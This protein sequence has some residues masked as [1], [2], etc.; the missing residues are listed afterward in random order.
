MQPIR[1]RSKPDRLVAGGSK[2]RKNDSSRG[3]LPQKNSKALEN[4]IT[5]D[6]WEYLESGDANPTLGLEFL[7]PVGWWNYVP[8]YHNE[9]DKV[10]TDNIDF[11]PRNS[12]DYDFQWTLPKDARPARIIDGNVDFRK[13]DIPFLPIDSYITGR[14]PVDMLYEFTKMNAFVAENW[15]R[16]KF[17]GIGGFDD[18]SRNYAKYHIFGENGETKWMDEEPFDVDFG[19]KIKDLIA[20]CNVAINDLIGIRP[21]WNHQVGVLLTIKARQQCAHLDYKNLDKVTDES[22][23]PW[24]VVLPLTEEGA[25]INVWPGPSAYVEEG[26]TFKN[27]MKEIP[28]HH[29]RLVIPFGCMLMLRSDIVHG[30]SF[31]SRGNTRMHLALNMRTTIEA[32]QNLDC[33]F[34]PTGA[35]LHYFR[36]YM[37]CYETYRIP[38]EPSYSKDQIAIFEGRQK[39]PIIR[40]MRP[41]RGR[42]AETNDHDDDS[43]EQLVKD[44]NELDI[45]SDDD[46]FD[47]STNKWKNVNGS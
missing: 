6:G 14:L 22:K 25:T 28:R 35:R 43:Q 39:R 47:E 24:I 32:T 11:L 18:K 36:A 26:E 9:D 16:N 45:L 5:P 27:N 31:G 41:P 7:S 29:V 33:V 38:D 15:L 1:S 2:K 20:Q 30:G 21:T 46:K 19:G 13:D 8:Q 42:M 40:K 23:L 10:E 3:C 44:M 17:S 12:L 37:D 4:K 34:S